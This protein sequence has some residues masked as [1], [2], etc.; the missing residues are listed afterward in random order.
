M[1]RGHHTHLSRVRPS[2]PASEQQSGEQRAQLDGE[3]V[4]HGERVELLLGPGLVLPHNL[5]DELQHHGQHGVAGHVLGQYIRDELDDVDAVEH[6]AQQ[7][8]DRRAGGAKGA[9]DQRQRVQKVVDEPRPR[10]GGHRK[11]TQLRGA[12]IAVVI[13]RAC[14]L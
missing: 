6:V 7:H 4:R 9:Y 3:D 13:L 2:D 14:P 1:R 8:G 11:P 12:R 10:A 5:V